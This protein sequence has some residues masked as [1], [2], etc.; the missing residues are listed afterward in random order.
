MIKTV[1]IMQWNMEQLRETSLSENGPLVFTI[2]VVNEHN[3]NSVRLLL[4]HPSPNLEI[5]HRRFFF[6]LVTRSFFVT[7]LFESRDYDF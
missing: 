6:R 7:L 2:K 4:A 1:I 5:L 3:I